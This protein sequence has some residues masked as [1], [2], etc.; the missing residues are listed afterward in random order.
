MHRRCQRTTG[1]EQ[2]RHHD[3]DDG[4]TAG[5]GGLD[6]LPMWGAGDQR[7]DQSTTGERVR[8]D[9]VLLGDHAINPR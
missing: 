2:R 1:D 8:L 9:E 5:T 3:A 4:G 6:L 7:R